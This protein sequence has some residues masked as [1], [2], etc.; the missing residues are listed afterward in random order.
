MSILNSVYNLL[1]IT[2]GFFG[3]GS[4]LGVYKR[5]KCYC[6]IQEGLFNVRGSHL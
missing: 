1:R 4:F 2:L 3:S 5:G 6:Y